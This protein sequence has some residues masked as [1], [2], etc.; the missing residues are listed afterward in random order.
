MF[1]RTDEDYQAETS[2]CYLS[3]VC[4]GRYSNLMQKMAR[5]VAPREKD[6]TY[7]RS[8][9]TNTDKFEIIFSSLQSFNSSK[10]TQLGISLLT[11]ILLNLVL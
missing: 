4:D 7:Q 6:G 5:G 3:D 2:M 11:F 8:N 10:V 1:G 9:V